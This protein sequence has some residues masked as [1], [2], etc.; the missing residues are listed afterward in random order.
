M[1][2]AP[3]QSHRCARRHAHVHTRQV[4]PTT[5]IGRL[6]ARASRSCTP[7]GGDERE[8]ESVPI[9][10]FS[11]LKFVPFVFCATSA[12]VRALFALFFHVTLIVYEISLC[13]AHAVKPIEENGSLYC[14]LI[15][16]GCNP[17][18]RSIIYYCRNFATSG[19]TLFVLT[20]NWFVAQLA[21]LPYKATS[22]DRHT[23]PLVSWTSRI[24]RVL[25]TYPTRNNLGLQLARQLRLC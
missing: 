11:R 13:L 2:G 12:F 4:R 24:G 18:D 17:S 10:S 16:S 8:Q 7:T 21:V 20:L 25:A 23:S 22:L 14:H 3:D 19:K 9:D 6:I 1:V 15:W 5:Y